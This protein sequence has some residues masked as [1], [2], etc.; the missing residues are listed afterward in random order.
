MRCKMWI[1]IKDN[2]LVNLSKFNKITVEEDMVVAVSSDNTF[3]RRVIYRG[4]HC[5]QVF[6]EIIVQLKKFDKFLN[7]ENIT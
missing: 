3:S 6:E 1:K 7:I 2:E 5:K 4:Y